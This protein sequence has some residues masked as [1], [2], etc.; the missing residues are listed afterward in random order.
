MSEKI[1]PKEPNQ[2]KEIPEKNGL[3][4]EQRAGLESMMPDYEPPVNVSEEPKGPPLPTSGEL[5]TTCLTVVFSILSARR[6]PHWEL[7]PKE[8][9]Q[10]GNATGAVLDKYCPDIEG[11]PEYALVVAAGMVLVPRVMVDRKI[12][13]EARKKDGDQS[14]AGATEQKHA[15]P[16]A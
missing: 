15:V 1:E 10:L 5:C 6:G 9:E 3:E 8:A 12:E 13:E 11:G 16:G 2:P 4:P 14:K 7:Q